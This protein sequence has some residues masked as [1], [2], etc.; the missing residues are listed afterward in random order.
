MQAFDDD[1]EPFMYEGRVFVSVR[2]IAEA[3]GLRTRW[4]GEKHLRN[5]FAL[6]GVFLSTTML[7]STRQNPYR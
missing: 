2:G 1:M 4:D 5:A 7:L 6:G 3:L